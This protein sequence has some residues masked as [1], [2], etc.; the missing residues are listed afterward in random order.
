MSPLFLVEVV[1]M[2]VLAVTALALGGGM[3]MKPG[4]RR[5]E[6][7]RPV[8]WAM[9]FGALSMSTTGLTNLCMMLGRNRLTPELGQAAF[10]GLAELIVP[11]MLTFAVLTVAWG[12]AAIGLRRLE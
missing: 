9:V 4:Q 1:V 3:A 2:V 6:M 11:I 7:L 12:L 5:Y 10:S 8:T